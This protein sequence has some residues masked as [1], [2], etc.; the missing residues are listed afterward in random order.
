LKADMFFVV[1]SKFRHKPTKHE[2]DKST[3]YF[4][5][6]SKEGTKVHAFFWTLGRYDSIAILEGKDEKTAM[7]YL[8]NFPFEIATETLVAVPR[9]E[10]LKMVK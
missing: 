10:A 2:L 3:A 6:M 7:Q 4:A 5:Q 8:V 9:E 1:L